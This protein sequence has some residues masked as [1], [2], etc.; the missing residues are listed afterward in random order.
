[1]AD[2][3]IFTFLASSNRSD[4]PVHFSHQIHT[5]L[6][7]DN[8]LVWKSQIVPVLRGYDL[9]CFIDGTDPPPRSLTTADGSISTNPAFSRWQQQD[10]LILAWI[11]NSISQ[12]IL[13]QVINCNSSFQLWLKLQQIHGSQ[14]LE[15]VLELKLQLQTSK[16]GGS[17]CAQYIQHMQSIADCLRSIGSDVSE[18]DLILYT[19][20]GLGSDYEN[21]VTAVSL[22]SRS[23][24]MPELQSLLFSHEARLKALVP[25]PIMHLTTTPDASSSVHVVPPV[26]YAG[27]PQSKYSQPNSEHFNRSNYSRGCHNSRGRGRARYNNSSLDK[28]QCQIC[29]RWGHTVAK[30]Y[31]RFDLAYSGTVSAGSQSTP[32]QPHH[33]LLPGL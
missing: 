33:A 14:S 30:C 11:F 9:M 28:P 22:R 4:A 29:F 24:S 25:S 5:I 20:Q 16:K 21:F 18:D 15:R 6:N 12:S 3:P 27:T 13:A 31:H 7:H 19:L 10:Q 26:L 32:S 1:M 8:Y 23:L 2:P 17:S